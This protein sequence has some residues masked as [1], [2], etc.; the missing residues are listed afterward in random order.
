MK[1]ELLPIATSQ[2]QETRRTN[3]LQLQEDTQELNQNRPPRKLLKATT[4]LP[5]P[6]EDTEN[7]LL[8]EERFWL[9][10][11]FILNKYCIHLVCMF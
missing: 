7:A 10:N 3:R 6:M 2:L 8:A 5:Q 1:E 9:T 4:P 11:L